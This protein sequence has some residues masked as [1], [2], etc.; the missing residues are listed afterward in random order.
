MTK[1]NF[2]RQKYT[3]FLRPVQLKLPF[4]VTRIIPSNDCVRLL[5]Q[6]VEEMDLNELY[7]TYSVVKENHLS[8]RQMLKIMLYAYMENIYSSRDIE[9]ACKRDINFMFLLD[10]KPAPDHTTIARFRTLH[11]APCAEKYMAMFTMLLHDLG[12]IDGTHIFVD[13]TKIEANANKYTFVWKKSVTKNLEKTLSRAAS[14]VE[15]CVETYGL[16]PVWQGHVKVKHLEKMVKQLY[17]IKESEGINF[18]H[19]PG[20]RKT[21][22]QKDI[23]AAE[24][25]LRRIKDYDRKLEICGNRNSYSKT[26]HDAT[27][28]RMKEDA[29]LNGQ[30]KPAYN[31]QI[32]VDSRYITWL[33][34]NHQP[35]DTSTLTEFVSGMNRSMD[36]RYKALIADAGYES[37]E[38]Y[39][40]L[41]SKG[42]EAYIKPSNYEI[43]KKR[44]VKSDISRKENMEYDPERNCYICM[45]KRDLNLTAT[46]NE[47][48]KSGY[49]REI[50]IY[51]CEDCSDCTFKDKCIKG[52][53]WKTPEDARQKKLYVS[54][55]FEKQRAGCLER[56][57]SETGTMLRMNRSIQ[58]E[59]AFAVLKEDKGF[60]QYLCR[61]R[62]NVYAESVLVAIAHNISTLHR[63]VQSNTLQSHLYPLN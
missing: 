2:L 63:K 61:G 32:G 6:V 53:N 46:K 3:A 5:D 1:H 9:K 45:N 54:R 24:E 41:E 25:F 10:G 17:S 37:E 36:F 22:L 13:G 55:K 38:N 59:G 16:K 11:F 42:I 40:F 51:A 29:M 43:S 23:E 12:E 39:T 60:R 57:T 21:Q 44:S 30:L 47:K 62:E 27:F 15:L 35:T 7:L 28:M 33:T 50:S 56:I 58:A 34:V 31:L 19:G 14:F 26:D 4:D 8:P 52:R 49:V 48:T 20:H 18:V